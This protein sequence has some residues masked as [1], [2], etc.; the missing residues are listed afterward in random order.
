VNDE[1]TVQVDGVDICVQAFGD[2]DDPTVLLIAGLNSSMDWWEPEFCERVAAAGRFVIRYDHRDTGRSVSYP[3]GAPGYRSEDLVADA[4]G[5]LAALDRPSAHVV[6]ISMGGAL[7]QLLTLTHPGIVDSLTLIST[8]A[9]AGDADLPSVSPELAAHFADPPPEPEWSDPAAVVE[10]IVAG[11]RPYAAH[12]MPFDETAVRAVAQRAVARTVNLAA[13][14]QN[15][16]LVEGG[17]SWRAR[18]GE[19]VAPTLVI[20][21]TE[22]PLFPIGHGE[23]L[24]REIH[25]ARLVPLENTGHELPQRVW[26]EVISAILAVTTPNWSERA[27]LLAATSVAAGEPTAWFER[28]YA[29]ARRGQSDIPWDR[30]SANPLLIQW[31]RDRPGAGRRAVVVGCGLGADAEYVAGQGFDTDAFD[32]SETAVSIARQRRPT[33]PVRYRAADALNLPA[34]WRRAFDLVVEIYTIQAL[35]LALRAD[36]IAAVAGLVAPGGTLIAIQAARPEI[37][38]PSSGPPWPLHRSEIDAFAVEGLQPVN[39]EFI[40][41][42]GSGERWRAEFTRPS[43]P[44][45]MLENHPGQIDLDR[46]KV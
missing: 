28:L 30:E 33:S 6:G 25:G 42:P 17:G 4:G 7:A 16:A 37:D 44:G 29:G 1:K 35:P 24:A 10:Y 40:A 3:A 32:I 15:H 18:L 21:G 19:I 27:D 9:G 38:E 5:V 39:I 26:D 36:V 23:A 11:A 22:D 8:S 14:Q 2:P 43:D 41:T 12:C 20:H 34:E 31:L 45:Q 13:S 46:R